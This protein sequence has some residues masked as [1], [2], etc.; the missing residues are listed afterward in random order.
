MV[1]S[2][3]IDDD[4]YAEYGRQN[5]ANPRAAVEAV[6]EKYA[7][8]GSGKALIVTGKPLADLQRVAG[9]LDEPEQ[10]LEKFTKI[11]SVNIGDLTF[12]LTESQL[13]GIKDKAAFYQKT[14]E[15]FAT[16][17]ITKALQNALGV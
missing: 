12:Q 9:Q 13:K 15:Q 17:Q 10:L 14:P 2:V 1:I 8:I 6:L 3:K 5:Q 16:E 7:R 4:T 11:S